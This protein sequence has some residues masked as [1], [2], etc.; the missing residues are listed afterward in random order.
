LDWPLRGELGWSFSESRKMGRDKSKKNV[1]PPRRRRTGPF[2][3]YDAQPTVAGLAWNAEDGI[4]A[5]LPGT[6]PDQQTLQRMTRA[7][8]EQI[9][10][11]PIWDDMVR[12]FGPA[13]AEA[14]LKQ[15]RAELR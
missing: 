5:L 14:L 9:R 12:E 4:D 2:K 13:K 1:K 3:N 11:S 10:K 7:Y 15:C 6:P 8:Q